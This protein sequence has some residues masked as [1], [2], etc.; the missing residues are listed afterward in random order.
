MKKLIFLTFALSLVAMTSMAEPID[1]S[2][3]RSIALDLVLDEAGDS[4][5]GGPGGSVLQLLY[6]EP[7]S[8]N[9]LQ[10]AYYIF[11]SSSGFVIVAGDDRATGV[12]AHG[13]G[14]LDM[15]NLP[16]AMQG[17]L[18]SYKE[19]I[20]FLLEHPGLMPSFNSPLRTVVDVPPLLSSVWGQKA[21]FNNDCPVY[22]GTRCV[23]GCVATAVAQIMYYW[24][25]PEEVPPLDPYTTSSNSITVP[26]LPSTTLRWND[27][28]PS[29]LGSS[30]DEQESAV[31]EL[32]RYVGQAVHMD[33]GPS[34]SGSSIS[35]ALAAVKQFGY[36]ASV[37]TKSR[38]NYT[39][40]DWNALLQA[41]L[42]A[43]RPVY[44]RSTNDNTGGGHAFVLNGIEGSTGK[45]FINWGWN[46][47]A[48]GYYALD[49]FNIEAY[50]YA[51]NSN[52][53]MI[54]GLRPGVNITVSPRALEFT[55]APGE[56]AT[57]T[58]TVTGTD[59]GGKLNLELQDDNGVY[60]IDKTSITAVEAANGITVTVT[61]SPQEAGTH[62]GIIVISGSGVAPVTI[63]LTGIAETASVISA[64]VDALDFGEVEVGYPVKRYL[65]VSGNNLT[66]NIYLDV[67]ARSVKYYSVSPTTIT[68]EQAANGV[69]VTVTYSPGS[70]Y[71]NTAELVLSS[72]GVD[73]VVLPLTASPYFPE[74]Q[75]NKNQTVSFVASIGQSVS[76]TGIVRFADV[77]I[78]D[79]VEPPLVDRGGGMLNVYP[80]LDGLA[81]YSLT[82]EGSNCFSA[83]ITKASSLANVCTVVITYRP[84]SQTFPGFPHKATLKVTCSKAGVPL[85]TI[86]LEGVS[87]LMTCEPVMLPVEIA[88]MTETSFVATWKMNCY[89]EGL[90]EFMVECAPQ[91]SDFDPANPEYR[92]YTDLSPDNC[93]FQGYNVLVGLGR[94][95]SYTIDELAT[96][97]AYSYRVKA[98][99][100]DGTWSDWSNVQIAVPGENS[101][102][103]LDGD[104]VVDMGDVVNL[105]DLLLY[106]SL[107]DVN[108]ANAD[109]DGDGE[110]TVNDV[111]ELIDRMLGI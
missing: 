67:R 54:V 69:K 24:K 3:A 107:D 88:K 103:D 19:Q 74:N 109:V 95:F 37:A 4:P 7:S 85:V 101:L 11:N 27:M 89:N 26:A 5:M 47:Y 75:F 94:K 21:P 35:R 49:A 29:Y 14:S 105:I 91:E 84:D 18:D 102:G 58:F 104:G 43:G 38:S 63:T 98:R 25:Y 68:P 106:G 60:T 16:C 87:N 53:M 56:T 65:T 59:L 45:Y 48:N 83:R 66:E 111:T 81:N 44:Y 99:F 8:V 86:P 79:P 110:V 31:A 2:T 17:L 61:Y 39:D 73:D 6:S 28:L 12:L 97:V 42:V 92:L 51:Y 62:N 33:Y 70:E 72:Q 64:S 55:A 41:E 96:D 57:E 40:S 46:G 1:V 50:N 90:S 52:H 93:P 15:N 20:D 23:S 71:W 32:L 13:S 80:G 10:P 108:V 36:S 34:A 100:I 82:I 9:V 76:Q 78:I 22:N 77:E 30:T